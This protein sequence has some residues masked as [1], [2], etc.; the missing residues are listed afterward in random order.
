[1]EAKVTRPVIRP[2]LREVVEELRFRERK[3]FTGMV[4][5]LIVEAFKARGLSSEGVSDRGGVG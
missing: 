4:E 2:G 1:M 5:L 3:T